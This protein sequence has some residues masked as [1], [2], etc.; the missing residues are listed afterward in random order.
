MRREAGELEI[1]PCAT[2]PYGLQGVRKLLS[3]ATTGSGVMGVMLGNVT[4]DGS[5]YARVEIGPGVILNSE[6]IRLH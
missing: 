1:C 4:L 6:K 2:S 5:Q 3:S